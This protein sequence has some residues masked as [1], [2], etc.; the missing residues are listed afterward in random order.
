[1]LNINL[2]RCASHYSYVLTMNELATIKFQDN[3]L[4]KSIVHEYTYYKHILWVLNLLMEFNYLHM[5]IVTHK[6][7]HEAALQ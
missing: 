6:C 4:N 2:I 5:V 7:Y 3:K 1:M